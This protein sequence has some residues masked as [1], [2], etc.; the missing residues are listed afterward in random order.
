MT[1]IW[2]ITD[3]NYVVQRLQQ[4]NRFTF[5]IISVFCESWILEWGVLLQKLFSSNAIND[6]RNGWNGKEAMRR[7]T[8]VSQELF[9]FVLEKPLRATVLISQ[10]LSYERSDKAQETPGLLLPRCPP[11]CQP[12]KKS[13]STT[14]CQTDA[15]NSQTVAPE[16]VDS[17]Q[18]LP[19]I[20]RTP[21]FKAQIPLTMVA[22]LH[23]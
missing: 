3:K 4:S 20:F 15:P 13:T 7:T 17:G 1:S 2:N 9:F 18:Q 10:H 19:S 8:A 21:K 23:T 14:R 5:E 22:G 12:W 11:R 16:Q 6:E